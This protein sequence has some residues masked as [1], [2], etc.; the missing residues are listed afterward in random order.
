MKQ[1]LRIGLQA[2]SI[3]PFWV[4]VRETIYRAAASPVTVTPLPVLNGIARRELIEGEGLA[5]V[6]RLTV[7]LVEIECIPFELSGDELV[8]RV[9]EV[10]ALEL[11]ALIAIPDQLLF[12]QRLVDGGLPVIGIHYRD[13]IRHRLFTC[14]EG[15][16]RPA[17][18]AC[19]LLAQRLGGRG[20]VLIVGGHP[21][22]PRH[23]MSSRLQAALDVF[24]QYPAIAWNHLPAP[25]DAGGAFQ[26]VAEALADEQAGYPL[27][28]AIFGLSDSLALAARDAAQKSGKT[29]AELL[30]VG[31]NGDPLAITAIAR[32]EMT[33]TVATTAADLA[34]NAFDL[35]CQVAQGR[36]LPP[37]FP[38]HP[39]VVT[40][41]NVAAVALNRLQAIADLPS[42][43]VGVNRQL[44]AERLKQLETS[45]AINR[46]M[47]SILD[48]DALSVAMAEVICDNYGYDHVR[49]YW[50]REQSQEF[51]THRPVGG[52]HPF[53][54][55]DATI[56]LTH[57]TLLGRA[58][59]SNRAVFIP[60]V[61]RTRHQSLA[62]DRTPMDEELHTAT[63]RGARLVLPVRVGRKMLGVLYL[64][65]ERSRNHAG[66]ELD[67][68]Q[69][70]ADQLGV[71]LRNAQLFA[72]AV[73]A[74]RAA[75]EADQLKSRLLSNVS[76]QLRTPLQ[77]ILGYVQSALERPE[78]GGAAPAGESANKLPAAEP[79]E[80]QRDL[81]RIQQA[82]RQLDRLISDLLDAAQA[83][84][85]GLDLVPE[86]VAPVALLTEVF[87]SVRSAA[88]TE[89]LAEGEVEWRL[90]L[91]AQL[92][93]LHADPLRLRQVLF[94]LLDNARH[95]TAEGHITLGAAAKGAHLHLWVADTGSGIPAELRERLFE[96]FAVGAQR[97]DSE[98]SGIGLGLT[99]TQHLVALHGGELRVE[100]YSGAGTVCQVHLPLFE[101]STPVDA[102]PPAAAADNRLPLAALLAAS[103]CSATGLVRQ[104]LEQIHGAFASNLT[105][106][107]LAD[108]LGVSPNYVSR[109]FREQIGLSPWEY[110]NRY[111]VLQA[112]ILLLESE[113]SVT[114]VGSR[115]GFNELAYF[116]RTFRKESGRSPHQFR[117]L[118][119]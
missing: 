116:S 58:L 96:A 87:E 61:G 119:R 21:A 109:L 78:F 98:R 62:A 13:E 114:E 41:A 94:H 1:L 3:D 102:P 33:A 112:Q 65:C 47:G 24:S 29:G 54:Q 34:G 72:E 27:F 10:L 73:D 107:T 7:E 67:A 117:R 59:L 19:E 74:R 84:T 39:V 83:Q 53:W 80:F 95:F 86:P 9:E 99:V 14:P 70:L 100:S 63:R 88:A 64:C 68:I 50:W 75:E 36:S 51:V 105:R 25:W 60:D 2:H 79:G 12:I 26:A 37:L 111:R 110:L 55:T 38:I 48:R 115:V 92:P 57:S 93:Q 97:G 45:L 49:F 89:G 66:A 81:H 85:G 46:Q 44:E 69:T 20:R 43:L 18:M 5:S 52:D 4:E 30:V 28:D 106:Q 15:L 40:N 118:R 103:T 82:G 8:T 91:P 22:Q 42:R 113:L 23:A 108:H 11:D 101:T 71:A 104:T 35:A 31:I 90:E 16:Y 32:G 76:Y 56:P 6:E 17:R 77:V